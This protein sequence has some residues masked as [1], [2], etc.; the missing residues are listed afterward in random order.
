LINS[1]LVN[2]KTVVFKFSGSGFIWFF[3]PI[4]LPL[5]FFFSKLIWG[6]FLFCGTG[7]WTLVWSSLNPIKKTDFGTM[8][9]RGKTRS[10]WKGNTFNF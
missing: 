3:L 7:I 6:S 10:V 1:F 9:S 4:N 8:F 5:A 2:K